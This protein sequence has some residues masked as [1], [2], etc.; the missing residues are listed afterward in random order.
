[1][2]KK[3][4]TL[5]EILAIL[6]ILA[7]IAVITVPVISDV[8]N[9]SRKSIVLDSAYGYVHAVNKF[10]ISNSLYKNKLDIENGT[11]TVAQMKTNGLQVNGSEPSE[12][13]IELQNGDVV[14][15]SLK[16][17]D[18]VVTKTTDSEP[19]VEKG[20]KIAGN[21][22]SRPTVAD[23]TISDYGQY[24]DLGT[25]LLDLAN[26]TLAD[27]TNPEADWRI[28]SKDTNG[29]W[30]ILADYLPVVEGTVGANVVSDLGLIS[31]ESYG[32]HSE[33]SRV[34][35]ITKLNGDW[36]GLIAGTNIAEKTGVHVK[37]AVD[38]P[39]WVSSWNA[40]AEYTQITITEESSGGYKINGIYSAE[41]WDDN[42]YG[43]TLYYPHKSAVN[44]YTVAYWLASLEDDY[45]SFYVMSVGFMG[46]V[47]GTGYSSNM[48]CV[49][50][51]VYLPSNISLDTTETVWTI[52]E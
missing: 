18:Y 38:L 22:L 6:I 49:R 3:G 34:D 33:V 37:G 31:S 23:I 2:N 17:N 13:W 12:G 15:Y 7:I 41:L 24:V 26:I 20:G 25:N 43:N 19:T 29:V 8:L 16:F 32:V 9:K 35:L 1:M 47:S 40:N 52:A 30:L 10:S 27:N 46:V 5:V 21:S 42:G 14:S 51:V 45:H 50:P 48:G 39:T 4:F 28:F 44:N 36:S 11:F